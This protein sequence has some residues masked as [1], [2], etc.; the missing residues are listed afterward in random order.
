MMYTYCQ[1]ETGTS[2]VVL[3]TGV[4]GTGVEATVLGSTR[5]LK[6]RL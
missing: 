2:V 4:L 5:R 1:A 6:G 3:G